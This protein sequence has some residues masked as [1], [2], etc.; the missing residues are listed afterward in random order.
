MRRQGV[1]SAVSF[2]EFFQGRRSDLLFLSPK[3]MPLALAANAETPE[4]PGSIDMGGSSCRWF[5]AVLACLA[6]VGAGCQVAV[7]KQCP[8]PATAPLPAGQQAVRLLVARGPNGATLAFVPVFINGEGPFRFTLDTGASTSTID[9]DLA[10]RLKLPVSGKAEEVTGVATVTKGTPVRVEEW[11]VGDVSLPAQSLVTLQFPDADGVTRMHGLLG[12]DVLS[13]YGA[14][15][16]DY[17]GQVL[18][19][20]PKQAAAK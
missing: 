9:A 15:L 13:R 7:E 2:A 17:R 3:G 16:V 14:V 11:R 1:Q 18:V 8:S 5:V 6:L 20:H 12:S 4:L 10:H 19:L